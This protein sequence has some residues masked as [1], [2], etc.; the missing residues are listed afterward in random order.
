MPDSER[1][2]ADELLGRKNEMLSVLKKI[3]SKKLDVVKIRI[4]GTLSLGQILL[5]G[6]DV[7]IHD[8]GGIPS[9]SYSETRLKRSPLTDVASTI[10]SFYYAGYEGFLATP[11]VKQEEINRLLPYADTWIHYM[12]GFFLK[13]YLETVKK[14]DLIPS[15][16]DDLKVM[17]QYYLL[18]K[19]LY[20]LRHEL[21]N[22]PEKVMIPLAM[23]K[24]IL[25]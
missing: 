10:R 11:H 13:A 17:L 1:A 4:H 5:T 25:A 18:D 9:R 2:A 24:D 14:T 7:A 19:A 16:S 8:F 6:K 12:S 20:A 21:L 23:I 15:S 3:Y 22:R